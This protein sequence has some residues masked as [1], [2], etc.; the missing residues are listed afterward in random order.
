MKW[1]TTRAMLLCALVLSAEAM[2]NAQHGGQPDPPAGAAVSSVVAPRGA[3]SVVRP[4]Y[5]V[6]PGDLLAIT[7]WGNAQL[8][9]T[10]PVRPDGRISLPLI[11]DIQASGYSAEQ[12]QATIQEK[13]GKYINHPVVGV[14]VQEIRSRTFN[15]LGK[16]DK[17]GSFD[18]IKPTT[19]LDAIAAAGGF[20]EYAKQSKV[21]VLRQAADGS[22]T[23]LHFNYKRVIKGKAPEQMIWL[24][25]GDTVVVP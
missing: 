20:K 2:A 25:P 4:D 23:I 18:L 6:G 22:R 24:Q 21:Y 10:M 9:R 19:V 7:V 5:V 1:K 3:M 8:S 16:V 14:V 12:L 13:L 11:G 17:P 15:V